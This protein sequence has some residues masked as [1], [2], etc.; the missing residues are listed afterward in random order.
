M[1]LNA[2][3]AV[4]RPVSRCRARRSSVRDVTRAGF[5]DEVAAMARAVLD[6]NH[7]VG[8][9][10]VPSMGY[11][12]TCP[13]TQ[14]YPFQWNWDSAFHAIALSRFDPIRAQTEIST[15]LAARHPSGFLPHMV[16]WQEEFRARA[17]NEFTIVLDSSG[18][19]SATVQPPVLPVAVERVWRASGDD[20]WLDVVLP[21][22]VAVMRWWSIHRDA[23]KTGLVTTFQPDES[24]L[25]MSPKYDVLLA[26]RG[27]A[28][29]A[30]GADD[31]DGQGGPDVIAARWHA[32]MRELFAAYDPRG[33]G[34]DPDE[35]LTSYGAFVWQDVLV[36]SIY[37]NSALALARLLAERRRADDATV[38]EQSAANT[39]TALL[40]DCWEPLSGAFYDTYLAASPSP[41]APVR[42]QARVLTA[43]SL[44]PLIIED[45]PDD[46]AARLVGHLTDE[47]EF[48]L[49]YPVPSVAATEPSFDPTF[50]S[51]AIFRGSS[52]VNLNWYLFEG[53]RTHGYHDIAGELARRTR[54]MV[55]L[56]GLRECYNPYDGSGHGALEFSWSSLVVDMS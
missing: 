9:T 49:P 51:H 18:W 7:R 53:L 28:D 5:A 29:G 40:R 20:E 31:A 11:D 33:A 24:G 25:D 32:A 52:W 19:R 30:D 15:L 22:L 3:R 17:A 4:Q 39:T 26:I 54:S 12:Y 41:T 2:S 45:I 14:T 46:V 37:A 36:N 6:R 27:N 35:D 10:Q 23:A 34:R 50:A 38:W 13:S 8:A 47:S 48:W 42:T 44:F 55:A 43:T 21:D 56:S 16:L 1:Q